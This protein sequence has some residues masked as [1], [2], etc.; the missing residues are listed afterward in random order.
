MVVSSRGDKIKIC[1]DHADLNVSCEA[2]T[3]P[4]TLCGGN[5]GQD[6]GCEVFYCIHVLDAKSE[7]EKLV[8]IKISNN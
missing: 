1:L 6:T 3:L 7:S 8:I 4:D 5:C 2:E